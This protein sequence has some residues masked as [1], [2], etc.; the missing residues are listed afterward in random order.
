MKKRKIELA[1]KFIEETMAMLFFFSSCFIRPGL[2]YQ[3]Q[4]KMVLKFEFLF[5]LESERSGDGEISGVHGRYSLL[6]APLDHL[7][8]PGPNTSGPLLVHTSLFIYQPYFSP[9]LQISSHHNLCQLLFEKTFYI[10]S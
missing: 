8:N 7:A 1:Q 10:Q 5:G 3:K 6:W 9:F 2:P 4:K